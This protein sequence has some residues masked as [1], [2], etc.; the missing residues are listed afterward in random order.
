MAIEI[1][2]TDPQNES[3][4]ALKALAAFIMELSGEQNPKF[5]IADTTLLKTEEQM[6]T[7]EE[8]EESEKIDNAVAPKKRGRKKQIS[9]TEISNF[10]P[11]QENDV[12]IPPNVPEPIIQKQPIPA[13]EAPMPIPGPVDQTQ[14]ITTFA[15]LTEK[16]RALTFRKKITK[17]Q[18]S[19]ILR[20][21]GVESLAFLSM[22]LHLVP[23]VN[24]KIDELL[25]Q[26]K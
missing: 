23:S 4:E 20:A 21:F 1:K 9:T 12:Y 24:E 18:I 6:F 10:P 3:K 7:N 2:I 19:D 22:K 11:K 17:Q 15:Q 5:L 13:P 14:P 25:A 26:G 8:I 16:L